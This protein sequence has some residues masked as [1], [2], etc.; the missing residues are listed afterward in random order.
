MP[1]MIRCQNVA[2]TVNASGIDDNRSLLC[3]K[4]RLK[5]EDVL[6]HCVVHTVG[7]KVRCFGNSQNGSM[8]TSSG[9]TQHYY[10][11]PTATVCRQWCFLERRKGNG[12]FGTKS[13]RNV[14]NQIEIAVLTPKITIKEKRVVTSLLR[15][16]HLTRQKPWMPKGNV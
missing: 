1:M 12:K 11:T 5:S 9:N 4:A 13:V 3:G 15:G 16:A 2:F 7:R 8:H 6:A 10:S 14:R